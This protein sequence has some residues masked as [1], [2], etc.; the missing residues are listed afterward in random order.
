MCTEIFSE[1]SGWINI[2]F[3]GV[4]DRHTVTTVPTFGDL[5]LKITLSGNNF[6]ILMAPKNGRH[7]QL[8]DGMTQC[9]DMEIR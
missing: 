2:N 4:V 6:Q 1:T 8:M 3:F 9:C 7:L 5:P